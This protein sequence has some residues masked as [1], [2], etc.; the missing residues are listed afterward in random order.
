MGR[1]RRKSVVPFVVL[2]AAVSIGVVALTASRFGW[3]R[4]K[5]DPPTEIETSQERAE[6][7][8][9]PAEPRF[10]PAPPRPADTPRWDSPPAHYTDGDRASP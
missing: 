10:K 7:E 6:P 5:A 8:T 2:G 9:N 4:T 3:R 1:R